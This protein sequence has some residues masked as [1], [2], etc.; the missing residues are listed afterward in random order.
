MSRRAVPI[1]VSLEIGHTQP[2]YSEEE[3]GR[4]ERW[5]VNH[6]ESG[7]DVDTGTWLPSV[8]ILAASEASYPIQMDSGYFSFNPEI[9]L[10]DNSYEELAM[11]PSKEGSWLNPRGTGTI[12]FS[13]GPV[14]NA[15]ARAIQNGGVRSFGVETRDGLRVEGSLQ[16]L[17]EAAEY[18]E[19]FFGEVDIDQVWE[20]IKAKIS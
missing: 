5:G 4:P 18:I 9:R 19:N 3:E 20:N 8:T 17:T 2:A 14:T 7:D 10:A 15:I 11:Q 16:E 1:N 13:P 6:F 12:F